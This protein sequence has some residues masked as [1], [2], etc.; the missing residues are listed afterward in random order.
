MPHASR[1]STSVN[2][3]SIEKVK[4]IVLENRC[5]GIREVAEGQTVN[6]E[7][8]LAVLRRLRKAIRCKQQDLWAD[9]SWFFHHD[10]APLHSSLM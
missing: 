8:Y 2:E 4:K 10:N 5:V 1:P 6:K 7:Y 9:N 3:D